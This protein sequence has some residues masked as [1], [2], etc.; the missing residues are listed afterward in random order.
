MQTEDFAIGILDSISFKLRPQCPILGQLY[1][2]WAP[3]YLCGHSSFCYEAPDAIFVF[4]FLNA[5]HLLDVCVLSSPNIEDH[6]TSTELLLYCQTN[7]SFLFG[8]V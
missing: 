8:C 5:G 1:T 6:W 7:L 2:N 3:I 4:F